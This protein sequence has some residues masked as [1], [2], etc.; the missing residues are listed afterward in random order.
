[1]GFAEMY[2]NDTNVEK[3]IR[4]IEV[5]SFVSKVATITEVRA[6]LVE[7]QK[8]MGNDKGIVMDGRDIGTVV[9]PNAELKIFMTAS[10]TIRAK[11]ALR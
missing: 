10:A 3:E 1:L 6:K 11:K 2:L 7:Q 5:S 8:E 4:T 9:F